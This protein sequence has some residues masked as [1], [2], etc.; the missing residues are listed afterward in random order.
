MLW[1]FSFFKNGLRTSAPLSSSFS[2]SISFLLPLHFPLPSSPCGTC[3]LSCLSEGKKEEEREVGRRR[4]VG[5]MER[6]EGC[7]E[8]TYEYYATVQEN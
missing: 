1:S 3:I 6:R 5:S 2:S 8:E 4:E 7:R